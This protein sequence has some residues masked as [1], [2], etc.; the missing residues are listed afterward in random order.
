MN[1]ELITNRLSNKIE[2]SVSEIVSDH[3]SSLG[4]VD[5]PLDSRNIPSSFNVISRT[6]EIGKCHR[7][8]F[9][10]VI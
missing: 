2:D 10:L 4:P 7:S 9:S 6:E 8:E 3:V 1:S 5:E